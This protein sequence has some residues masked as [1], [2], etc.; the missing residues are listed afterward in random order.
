METVAV[1]LHAL[2]RD[3]RRHDRNSNQISPEKRALRTQPYC[4]SLRGEIAN[5]QLIFLLRALASIG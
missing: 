1:R 3:R 4:L 2:C 5:V